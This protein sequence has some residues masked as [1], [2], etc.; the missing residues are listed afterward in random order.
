MQAQLK[1]AKEFDA[2]EKIVITNGYIAPF[3]DLMN[4]LQSLTTGNTKLVSS[5]AQSPWYKMIAKYFMHGDKLIAKDTAKRYF[6][7]DKNEKSSGYTFITE[8]S[9]LFKIIPNSKK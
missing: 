6:P 2:N 9:K 5:Q 3:M 7:A 8:E 4:Q 1:Q